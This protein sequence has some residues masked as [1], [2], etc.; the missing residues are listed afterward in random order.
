MS[1]DAADLLDGAVAPQANRNLYGHDE[2][3]EFLAQTYRSGKSHHAILIEGP[4][5]IGKATLAFRFANHVLSHADPKSAP[6]T[7][8]P[9][10]PGSLAYR[11]IVAGASHN[12][13]HLTRPYDEKAGRLKQAI[14]IEEVRKAGKFFA[15]TS[16]SDNWRIVIVDTADDLNR[17]AA[18]AILKILEEPPKRAMF[19][20]LSHSPGKLLPTIRSRCLPLKLR[21]L[22]GDDLQLALSGLGFEIAAEHREQ[23]VRQSGG[24]VAE[25]LKLV[26][27][28]GLDILAAF[29]EVLLAKNAD[30][31]RALHKLADA[32]SARGSDTI[33][34]FFVANLF[35]RIEDDARNAALRGA[36]AQAEGLA[37]LSSTLREKV[38]TAIAYN[39]DRKQTIMGAV[40]DYLAKA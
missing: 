37:S 6:E 16:G 33:F 20:V 40:E 27:Y 14:T 12:L 25:A 28:G 23:L 39:L 1:D 15:Q 4:E 17:N 32:L 8:G 26:N 2:A 5:G 13:L 9:P 3:L 11:Q 19:L 18:N 22:S 38:D 24:S 7:I 31:R 10:D 34:N 35:R 21:P 36:L 30:Q 29:D